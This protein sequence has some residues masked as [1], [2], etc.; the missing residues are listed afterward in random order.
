[1]D[2]NRLPKK[3]VNKWLVFTAMPFQ[4][5]ATIYVFYLLGQYL[6]KRLNVEG[7]WWMKGLTLL[8]VA[9]SLYQFIRQ[10]KKLN[11]NE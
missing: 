8:G 6:D 9:V 10:A 3:G 4:M 11:D 5:G 2:E 7:E 1:M